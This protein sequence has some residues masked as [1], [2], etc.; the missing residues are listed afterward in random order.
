MRSAVDPQSMNKETARLK[1]LLFEVPPTD[2]ITFTG[3]AAVLTLAALFA[4]YLPA[5][6]VAAVD[7]NRTLRAE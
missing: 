4:S 3:V 5:R 1:S 7:P 2:A 6:R